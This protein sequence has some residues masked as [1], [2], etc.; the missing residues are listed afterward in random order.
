M[1]ADPDVIVDHR[2]GVCA[3]CGGDLAEA[4]EEG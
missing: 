3:G 2:L 4:A 1:S